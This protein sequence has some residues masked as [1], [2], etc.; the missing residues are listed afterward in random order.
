MPHRRTG[1]HQPGSTKPVVEPCPK[2]LRMFPTAR[3]RGAPAIIIAMR[4][5][6]TAGSALGWDQSAGPP[7]G[8]YRRWPGS[9]PLPRAL[10]ASC[11]MGP[12][13]SITLAPRWPRPFW[14]CI[15]MAPPAM[16]VMEATPEALNA[17][18]RSLGRAWDRKL[19]GHDRDRPAGCDLEVARGTGEADAAEPWPRIAW[20]VGIH[21][22]GPFLSHTKRGRAP[23][24]AAFDRFL[25]A[26]D[27]QIRLMTLAPELPGAVELAAP[28]NG[29]QGAR[30][31]WALQCDRR[32]DPCRDCSRSGK[33]N[34]HLQCHARLG[35]SRTGNSGY[36]A[37]H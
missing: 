7:C 31:R 2:W 37:H 36:C 35:S 17:M 8:G 25:E 5:V 1:S 3:R 27:G 26:A 22:E 13:F 30:L 21:L 12:R 6:I 33:R 24:V 4:I 20:P 11:Q 18:G 28:R 23:D 9:V 29:T 16:T 32:A 10:T 34:A 19:P 15:R 14:M